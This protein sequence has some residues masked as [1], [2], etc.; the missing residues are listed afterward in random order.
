MLM[1]AFILLFSISSF[2]VFGYAQERE[3]AVKNTIKAHSEGSDILRKKES[4][5][6]ETGILRILSGKKSHEFKVE[7][8][9]TDETRRKGLM[10]RQSLEK[11]SGMLF[12][13]RPKQLSTIWMKN[14][15]LSLDILFID[16]FGKISRIEHSAQPLSHR[17]IRSDRPISA[18]L[19]INGGL[20]QKLGISA[21]DI[22]EYDWFK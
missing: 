1:K 15:P 14:T 7:I 22:I 19:E 20:S 13:F 18:V 21:G 4:N 17:L 9:D 6:I 5:P 2:A 3:S 12:D 8:A 10:N 11:M 16:E